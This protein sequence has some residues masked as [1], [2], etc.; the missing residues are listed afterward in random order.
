[1]AFK[2]RPAWGGWIEML[3]APAN[4]LRIFRP[5][6]H[7]A[8]GLKYQIAEHIVTHVKSRPAW[9]GWIEMQASI[10]MRVSNEVPPRMGRV[11]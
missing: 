10:E 7:G 8:G 6:P 5:A 2:S 9:G 11:D 3:D 1:M 4:Q